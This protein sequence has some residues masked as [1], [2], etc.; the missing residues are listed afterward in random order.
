MLTY[1][2]YY[3]IWSHNIE[4]L[5]EQFGSA[6]CAF[7]NATSIHILLVRINITNQLSTSGANWIK[8]IDRNRIY[9]IL[10]HTNSYQWEDEIDL[11]KD[12]DKVDKC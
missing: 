9:W 8:I 3:D 7:V 11:G 12:E 1:I 10:A 6:K 2:Q 5:L 4:Q